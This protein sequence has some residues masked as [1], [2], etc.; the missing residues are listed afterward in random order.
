MAELISNPVICGFHP[1]R[2]TKEQLRDDPE[3]PEVWADDMARTLY[4]AIGSR[5][6]KSQHFMKGILG[7]TEAVNA[8]IRDGL[9][10]DTIDHLKE[11]L[12]LQGSADPALIDGIHNYMAEHPEW[13]FDLL[14][15]IRG[16]KRLEWKYKPTF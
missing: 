7:L 15:Y 13:A 4:L 6:I 16:E 9:P 11:C 5:F 8:R 2:L 10:L 14:E 12:F 3:F 1:E